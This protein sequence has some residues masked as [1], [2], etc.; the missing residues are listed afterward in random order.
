[1][2]KASTI[3]RNLTDRHL[4][5][6]TGGKDGK[7]YDIRDT[8]IRGLRVRV[9]PSGERT[10]VLLARY[11]PGADPTRR[12]LGTYPVIGLADA[13]EKARKWRELIKRGIDPA[14][15]EERDRA[16]ELRKQKTTF[17]AVAEDFIREKLQRERKGHEAETD[18]RREFIPVWGG[19]PATDITPL[20]VCAVVKRVRNE[21][22]IYQAHN[23]LGHVRRLYNWAIGQHLYGIES[24]PCDR[25]RP[26][27][28]IGEKKERTRILNDAELRAA[29][30]A[31]DR[32]GYP[33]GPLFKLLIL[34]GQRKSEVAEAQWSEI[35]S[36]KKIWTIPAGR[37]KA[38]AAHVLP[39]SDD[40]MEVL[41]SL[42]RFDGG[43]YLFSVQFGK[44]PVAAFSAAKA[45]FDA[46]MLKA[47]REAEPK[48]KLAGFV[49]HDIRRTV[50]TGLSAIPNI[51][52]LVR[53]LVI[54]HTKPGLH[55]VYDQYAYLDEKRFA[56]DAWAARLRSIIEPPPGNVVE[57]RT[58]E[59]AN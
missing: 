12:A 31:A 57:L 9:M 5:S 59:A 8:E 2:A 50:R 13:R 14:Q 40:A 16:A 3:K 23:L 11:Q 38:R 15:E 24:S 37:M 4:R 6:L 32:I 35:D 52:D 18:I 48:A 17:L 53:E 34:T 26:R 28:I 36:T 25:L 55:K 54:A 22:K 42:P 19:R 51:S 39:L 10:F 21:G 44:R 1:M 47:I 33:Y 58:R 30:K 45:R 29:W 46:E 7:P 20:D 56:L 49:I 27:E 41:G 43:D